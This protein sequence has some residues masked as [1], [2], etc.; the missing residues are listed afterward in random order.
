MA[1]ELSK[2]VKR[3]IEIDGARIEVTVRGSGIVLRRVGTAR[4]LFTSFERVAKGAE[5]PPNMPARHVAA[6]IRWLLEK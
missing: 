4:R 3:E 6:P 2:P 1:T 5:L